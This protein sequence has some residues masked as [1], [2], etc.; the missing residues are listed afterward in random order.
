MWVCFGRPR[1]PKTNWPYELAWLQLG[2]PDS[3]VVLVKCIRSGHT[4]WTPSL[5]VRFWTF[6]DATLLGL[7]WPTMRGANV[8]RRAA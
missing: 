2:E 1:L 4:W 5:L 8:F 7:T 3:C 6:R